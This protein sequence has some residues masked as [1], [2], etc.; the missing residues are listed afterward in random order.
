MKRAVTTGAKI[1]KL[2]ILYDERCGFCIRC[3]RWLQKQ[4][5][6]VVIEFLPM[7]S[8]EALQRYAELSHL[9]IQ[10]ERFIVVANTGAVYTGSHA[11]VMC[12][13]ALKEYR[14]L[15]LTLANP[16]L[17][18]LVDAFFELVSQNRK[19]ISSLLGL[20]AEAAKL[21]R[22]STCSEAECSVRPGRSIQ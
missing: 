1:K 5:A 19:L 10:L 8:K 2:T 12:M 20:K 4:P 15:S 17:F 18:P 9:I 16:L 3:M 14:A 7:H 6:F 13:W 11:R 21:K 22:D